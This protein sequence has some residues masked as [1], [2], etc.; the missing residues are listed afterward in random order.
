MV[1]LPLLSVWN[2]HL[3]LPS[4]VLSLDQRWT[5]AE[6]IISL[7]KVFCQLLGFTITFLL[8]PHK[9]KVL[10]S[11]PLL[12]FHPI[13]CVMLWNFLLNV[14]KRH[15]IS[16][17]SPWLSVMSREISPRFSRS[18][19]GNHSCSLMSLSFSLCAHRTQSI[20]T[21]TGDWWSTWVKHSATL[22]TN[23]YV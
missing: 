23:K 13:C 21:G 5:E 16:L 10:F 19:W 6:S 7:T 1:L 2:N 14:K 3:G 11:F 22:Y 4:T 9:V 18:I 15:P 17:T 20:K 8:T 12:H